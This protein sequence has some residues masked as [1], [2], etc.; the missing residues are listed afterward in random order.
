MSVQKI[1]TSDGDCVKC[2]GD[3]TVNA[4]KDGCDCSGDNQVYA[5][6][7]DRCF[8]NRLVKAFIIVEDCVVCPAGTRSNRSSEDVYA[9]YLPIH[10]IVQLAG[11]IV[12]IRIHIH[13]CV[14]V[15]P[16]FALVGTT[17]GDFT[18]A[19][20]VLLPLTSTMMHY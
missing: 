5:K 12:A 2:H 16:S 8:C 17:N 20:N 4:A 11:V 6:R 7:K 15:S 3:A 14:C 19:E 9:C 18:T 1:H 10:H 13:I